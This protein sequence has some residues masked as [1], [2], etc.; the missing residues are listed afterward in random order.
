VPNPL[1]NVFHTDRRSGTFTIHEVCIF[2][3]TRV[4]AFDPA[5]T[6]VTYH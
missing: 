3:P 6:P 4:K 5:G 1:A 2:P